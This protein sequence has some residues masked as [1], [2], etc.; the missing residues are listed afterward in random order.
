MKLYALVGLALL[1]FSTTALAQPA[2][3]TLEQLLD[4]LNAEAVLEHA[5]TL[6]TL[7]SRVT[8]YRGY[9]ASV[10]YIA[11]QLSSL[12]LNPEYRNFTL[13]V[14]VD[15]GSRIRIPEAGAEIEA[16]ALWPN[17]HVGVWDCSNL[18]G[19][20]VYVGE[21]KLEDFDGKDV[22]GAIVVMDFRSGDN[23]RYA[24]KFGARAVVFV[25]SGEADR[26]EAYS[27]FEWYAFYPFVR[28]Y[29][30]GEGA[31]RLVECALRG[32]AAVID[33]RISLKAVEASNL[34]VKIPGRRQDEAVLVIASID[35]WS[36]VPALAQSV[37]DALNVGFL[38]ELAKVATRA[39][40]ERSLWVA[41]LSGRWQ[42]L[43]GARRM[44][45]SF[46]SDPDL[47]SGRNVVWY[48]V[49]VDFSD[50]FPGVS[51]VY[52]GHFYRAGRALLTAKYS[53]VQ[54]LVTGRLNDLVYA[55]LSQ[56]KLLPE[57]LAG[58]YRELGL[59]RDVDLVEGPDWSWTGTM[60]TPY[61]LDT[62]PFV[63]ANMAG[64][65]I[66]T[67]FSFRNW[68][69]V[70]G[71]SPVRWSY[72]APQLYQAAAL[73]LQML[74]AEEVRLS[75]SASIPTRF[76]GLGG[77]A[78]GVLLWGLVS[79]RVSVASFNLST[80]WYTPVPGAIVRAWSYP[81]T[82][83]FACALEGTGPD[84][85]AEIAGLSPQGVNYWLIEAV[86]VEEGSVYVVDHGVYGV[87]PAALVV[88]AL[89]DPMPVFVPVFKGGVIVLFDVISPRLFRTGAMDDP[90]AGG[91]RVWYNF[92][93]EVKVYDIW[94]KAEPMHWSSYLAPQYDVAMVAAPVGSRIVVSAKP[95]NPSL[96]PRPLILLTNSTEQEPEGLGVQV[97]PGFTLIA[98][99]TLAYS[100]DTF[101]VA[102]S[103]YSQLK[104]KGV[105]RLSAEAYEKHA[106]W[107]ISA[108]L[109]ATKE[110]RYSEA[111]RYSLLALSFSARYYAEE[112]MP[113][114]DETARTAVLMLFIVLPSAYL[115]ERLLVHSE[116]LKRVL[117]VAGVG[118]AALLL[119]TLVHPAMTV[120]ANSAMSVLGTSLLMIALLVLAVFSSET[121]HALRSY[122]AS[123]LGFHEFRREEISAA[124][125][126]VST[127]LEN[128]R[129]RPL[130]SVLT[131]MSIVA[132][133]VAVVSL[134][135]TSPTV[136]T[137]ASVVHRP[138]AYEG[139]AV[140]RG[141]GV[142]QEVLSVK[143]VEA[144]KGLAG[145][146]SVPRVWLYP[147]SV[148]KL[149][150]YG[151]V[152]GKSGYIAV[153]AVLGL[154]PLEADKV[155]SRA[156]VN[157]SA[158]HPRHVYACLL[159]T[160]Q[161]RSLG[162][163]VGDEIEY[164]GLK[165]SVAGILSEEVLQGL[166]GDPD[167][168]PYVPLDP[169]Y[170]P[171]LYGFAVGG[172]Q[173][174]PSP[175]AW[176][177]VLVVTD[178]LAL[179]L[180]GFVNSVGVLTEN[181]TFDA[182]MD[183]ARRACY[184]L[185]AGVSIHS[186]GTS[187]AVSRVFGYALFG[188]EFVIPLLA[189][190]SVSVV[191]TLLAAVYERSREMLV[192]SALGLSPRGAALMFTA[193]F[194]VYG[195]LGAFIGYVLG[196]ALSWQFISM[197]LLPETYVFNYASAAVILALVAVVS[198]CLSSAAYP[199]LKASRLI[200][201]SLERAWKPP[202]KPRGDSWEVVF[203]LRLASRGEA[204]GLL[205]YLREYYEGAGSYKPSFRVVSIE[206]VDA[207][208]LE[209]RARVLVAPVESGTEQ[210]VSIRV[211]EQPGKRYI[212]GV[213]A[214]LLGGSRVTWHSSAP[215]FFD[216]MRKQLLLW[217][218]LAGEEKAKY[219]SRAAP[220]GSA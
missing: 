111:Y 197:G 104:S 159:T 121:S 90:R 138:A 82:Y 10:S 61:L 99:P 25:G 166:P 115:L 42:G 13:L 2:P 37:H 198:V 79:F 175:L 155:L 167:G 164:S 4:Q 46:A 129:K 20:L 97:K 19:K 53:W 178:A 187:V 204:L 18:S 26:Y 137:S 200:T 9:Y 195:L 60:A 91:V 81:H 165:L 208:S 44:A 68:E 109:N 156:V 128:M 181:S 134:T 7:G 70:P 88:G 148:N 136:L 48:V 84:G 132:V 177:R 141:F 100:L 78:A 108:A 35:S 160:K 133:A 190:G 184:A 31:E 114:Y 38:L 57:N 218:S 41:F 67:Q 36:V 5:Y 170:S 201:P 86:K 89:Q 214:K 203:P 220:A 64:F 33:S 199:A 24:A 71:T 188:W 179:K 207:S 163:T 51:L 119:F 62:E 176:E 116:G 193:E 102:Q 1:V 3:K 131:L 29:V 216:D 180:G 192:F 93:G 157:G 169:T 80:G 145:L 124:L 196:W 172:G 30:E 139:L 194:L 63:V 110:R 117:A 146:A 150:P 217:T 22:E 28:L 153:Q 98:T 202:T 118:A 54:E 168:Y 143:T 205:E 23:W 58:A 85:T 185:D 152:V 209:L 43:A 65:T 161:A 103:R 171:T 72:V 17:G 183:L 189:L 21:G 113:L 47:T 120:L 94:T 32:Y 12:G 112:V 34:L 59:I 191:V 182:M 173:I 162:V 16:Y 158:F 101:R 135:S 106:S 96:E 154:N 142:L 50:D 75:R 76:T 92:G 149:G 83:P 206:G 74:A 123:K 210:A 215:Y 66:R 56:R 27:K 213:T 147:V 39:R 14:P 219:I 105:R 186:N 40:L 127:A 174:R 122:A 15:G 55:Y 211:I 8:G 140:R 11:G 125:I 73:I 49:G 151:L 87:P 144:L 52:V 77:G 95:E 69:G 45:D 212:V 107:Y 6:S 126:S 130:R